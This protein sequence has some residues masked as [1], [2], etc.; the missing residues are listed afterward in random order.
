MATPP[1]FMI[2]SPIPT[3]SAPSEL[4]TGMVSMLSHTKWPPPPLLYSRWL[5]PP[6]LFHM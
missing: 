2:F 1:V 4:Y 5:S 6:S 3:T